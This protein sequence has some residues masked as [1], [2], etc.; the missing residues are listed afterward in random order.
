MMHEDRFYNQFKT[1][2]ENYAPEVPAAAYSG[3]RRKLWLSQFLKFNAT[4]LNVWYVGTAIMVS[5]GLWLGNLNSAAPAQQARMHS[6]EISFIPTMADAMTPA[7]LSSFTDAKC[8]RKCASK[9]TNVQD[10]VYST[11]VD[12]LPVLDQPIAVISTPQVAEP[13][14]TVTN[15]ESMVQTPTNAST[16]TP[17]NAV[18]ESKPAKKAK[19]RKYKVP[20]Y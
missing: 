15:T 1:Q 10:Q 8:D 13:T 6:S 9:C 2:L 20:R 7:A 18:D 11:D 17:I 14:V 4:S 19:G 16:E 5:A 3:M 12:Q